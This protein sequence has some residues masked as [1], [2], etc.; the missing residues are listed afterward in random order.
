LDIDIE[1]AVQYT[2]VAFTRREDRAPVETDLSARRGFAG[3][4]MPCGYHSFSLIHQNESL[5]LENESDKL[6]PPKAALRTL[7]LWLQTFHF[8]H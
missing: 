2:Q 5:F 4:V 8:S 6:M 3:R 1:D 7:A